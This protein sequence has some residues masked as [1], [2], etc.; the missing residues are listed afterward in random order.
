MNAMEIMTKARTHL[1]LDHPFFGCLAMRLSLVEDNQ[2]E[3][4]GT[5]GKELRFN[6]QFI[7][8]LRLNQVVGL[9]AHEVMHLALGHNWRQGTREHERWNN[10]GDYAINSNLVRTGIHLP[11][12]A[13]I[14]YQFDKMSAEEIY[15]YLPS[16]PNQNQSSGSSQTSD[17]GG[18]GA[19]LPTPNDSQLDETKAEWKTAVAQAIQFAGIGNLPAD[20]ARQLQSV[21]DPSLP[22]YVL[23]RDFVERSARNDFTW[24]RP[25]ARYINQGIVLPGLISEELPEVIVAVDTSGSI[26][27]AQLDSFAAEASA[28]LSAYKTTI[29]V[30]YC[31]NE[32]QGEQIYQTDDLPIHLSPKGGGGTKFDPVFRY[33]NENGYTP[34]CVIYL[35]DLLGPTP[36]CEPECPVLWVSTKPGKMPFGTVIQLN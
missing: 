19:V 14:A 3:T 15:T 24:Q 8:S 5:D 34:S 35:T 27:Q 30:I 6:S 10:A 36:Q 25:N 4:A 28:V 26:S 1:L 17:P 11:D 13:L 12:G 33:V 22:W 21:I 7:Q 16:N 2:F 20:L 9:F 18:C 31:D 29:R 32:V 23:L